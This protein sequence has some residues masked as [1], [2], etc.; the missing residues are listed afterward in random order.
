MAV[1]GDALLFV[2]PGL[3]TCQPS[4]RHDSPAGT[5]TGAVP[6]DRRLAVVVTRIRD[7]AGCQPFHRRRMDGR[8]DPTPLRTMNAADRCR[9]RRWGRDSREPAGDGDGERRVQ[10]RRGE[11]TS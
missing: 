3:N 9:N 7:A 2:K 8:G 5:A 6:K 11:I 4:T 1:L 10:N